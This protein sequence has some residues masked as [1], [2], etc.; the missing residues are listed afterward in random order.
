MPT[1]A[2][3]F[4][5]AKASRTKSVAAL[6]RAFT[7]EHALMTTLFAIGVA[8][9]IAFH[10]AYPRAFFYPDSERYLD[11]A[12]RWLTDPTRPFGYSVFL[13]P[14][15]WHHLILVAATQHIM[16]LGLALLAYRFLLR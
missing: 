3:L 15:G 7:R 4:E 5:R 1:T 12:L 6:R 2:S 8:L 14:F 16:V 13:V 11:A 10:F 9:R